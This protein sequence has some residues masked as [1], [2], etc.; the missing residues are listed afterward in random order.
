V[1]SLAAMAIAKPRGRRSAMSRKLL[2]LAL[3]CALTLGV[4]A[5]A[6]ADEKKFVVEGKFGQVVS[7]AISK[8]GGPDDLEIGQ[9]VR[10]DN[11][12]SA[13]PEWDGATITVYEQNLSYPS[14]GSYRSYGLVHTRAGDVAYVELAGTWDVVMQ[15]GQFVDAPFE[16][17]GRFVGGT[18]KLEGLTGSVVVKGKVDGKQVGTYSAEITASR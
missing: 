4:A 1:A 3:V 6:Q 9:E 13:D 18:G 12:R 5:P 2:G 11:V 15:N 8:P 17:K 14:H 10:V 7:N 16:A